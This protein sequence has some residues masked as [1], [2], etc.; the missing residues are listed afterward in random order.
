MLRPRLILLFLV[1]LALLGSGVAQGEFS[2]L[3]NL[4]INFSGDFS[5]HSLPR[6]RP[7]PLTIHVGGAI[8]TT[9]GTHPPALRKIV[10]ELNGSGRISSLGL[11]VC[12][13]AKLQS[14]TAQA[15]MA[16]CGSALVGR[17]HFGADVD[18]STPFP[19]RGEML[20]FNGRHGGRQALLL[21]LSG[22]APVQTTF[23]LP[24]T[25]SHRPKGQFGTVLS[26]RIPT[27]AAGVGSV[28]EIDLTIGRNYTY[29]GKRRSF[30]SAACAAPAGFPGAVFSLAK[31]NFYFVDGR[32]IQT[33]LQRNC[34]VR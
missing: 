25:I 1:S 13:S 20:A 14:T 11:P 7:A 8:T 2:Q 29:R 28:S 23:V 12:A 6:D 10:I 22:T 9:D 31:G 30:I 17:G 27:L 18:F 4:R 24:L 21:H 5:P 19:A 15:A 3:G 32:K 16:R 26:A 34:R 33:T